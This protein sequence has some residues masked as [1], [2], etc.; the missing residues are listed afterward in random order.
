MARVWIVPPLRND[1]SAGREDRCSGTSISRLRN[2]A[3]TFATTAINHRRVR[4][5]RPAATCRARYSLRL[6]F[7]LPFPLPVSEMG[8]GYDW[9][10]G[11]FEALPAYFDRSDVREKLHLPAVSL[12]SAFVYNSSGPASI[13]LYP[14]L[15]E[16]RFVR[17]ENDVA[18]ARTGSRKECNGR[19]ARSLT[20]YPALAG[21]GSRVR[22][23][24]DAARTTAE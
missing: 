17:N 6:P 7:H 4:R 5:D 10:C 9:T 19:D 18:R 24:N 15:A 22:N 1:H 8:G 2:D 11:T 12:T 20:L 21:R 14:A 3:L 16:V 13:T 23:T